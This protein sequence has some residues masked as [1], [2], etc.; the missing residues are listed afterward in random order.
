MRCRS[1]V[2]FQS[3]GV[4]KLPVIPQFGVFT[5]SSRSVKEWTV[6]LRAH[7]GSVFFAV[8][9]SFFTWYCKSAYSF[10][11]TNGAIGISNLCTET[12]H[13]IT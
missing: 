11:S 9:M 2:H 4:F 5:V 7:V 12:V 13:Q 10:P 3:K 1:V 6:K 8:Q